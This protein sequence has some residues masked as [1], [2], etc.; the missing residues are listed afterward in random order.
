MGGMLEEVG[1]HRPNLTAKE[2]GMFCYL[3]NRHSDWLTC[4]ERDKKERLKDD[5]E[6]SIRGGIKSQ[7]DHSFIVN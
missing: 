1:K 5:N 3:P 7:M 4:Y 6:R 2:D